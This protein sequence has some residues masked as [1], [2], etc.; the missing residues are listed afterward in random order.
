MFGK[1]KHLVLH[2]RGCVQQ[3]TGQELGEVL[4]VYREGLSPAASSLP[5]GLIAPM[6]L[7][8]GETIGG[9]SVEA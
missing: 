8:R 9:E 4:A 6:G 7:G 1:G 3:I 5:K 2:L